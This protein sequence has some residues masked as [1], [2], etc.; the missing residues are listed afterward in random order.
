MG[1]HVKKQFS[2]FGYSYWQKSA[3]YGSSKVLVYIEIS[4]SLRN[5]WPKVAR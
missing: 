2:L 3:L 1:K 5:P 4:V